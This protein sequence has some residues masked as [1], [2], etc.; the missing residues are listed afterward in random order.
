MILDVWYYGMFSHFYIFKAQSLFR[1]SSAWQD[2]LRYQ[3][4]N[5]DKF[6]GIRRLTLNDNPAIG[7]CGSKLLSDGLREDMWVKA[8]DLQNC[9]LSDLAAWDWLSILDRQGRGGRGEGPRCTDI[10]NKTIHIIDLR[11][12]ENI[13]KLEVFA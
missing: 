1:T 6:G 2:S 8:V 9:G 4:P 10:G 3:T 11:R 12:N 5:F 13:G 7:N